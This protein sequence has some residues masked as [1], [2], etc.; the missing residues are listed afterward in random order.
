MPKALIS[1]LLFAAIVPN[2]L[3]QAAPKQ[4]AKPAP[5]TASSLST[6]AGRVAHDNQLPV[7][8]VVLYKNGV[9]YFEHA[10]RVRGSQE[11]NIDFTT[12]QLNDVL[13]SLTVVDMG[14]GQ[15][16]GVRYNSIA[17]LSERLRTLRVQL[18]EDTTRA[19]FLG[20]LRGARVEVRSGGTSTLGKLLSVEQV[21][22][23][24]GREQ[25]EEITQFA[26]VTDTGEM[27][28]FD[29][30]PAVSVRIAEPELNQEIGQYMTAI[31]SSRARDV[32]RMS[33]GTA[34]TGERDLF[35]S[36]ISEVPVWKSTY[37][38]LLPS[39]SGEKALLQGWAI[40][41][42]TV[43]E[44]WK[45][46]QLSLVAGSP[47]SFIQQISQPYYVRR[48]SI[49]LPKS[50]MLTPQTHEGTMEAENAPPPPQVAGGQMGGVIGGILGSPPVASGS[51]G[52]G[53][54]VRVATP[55]RSIKPNAD[56]AAARVMNW[57]APQID[58][59]EGSSVGDLF[60]YAIKQ[61]I[62]VSKNQSALVPIVNA[63]VEAEK[64]T[65]W[66]EQQKQPLRALWIKNSSGLTLDG[67]TFNIVD[68]DAFAGEGILTQLHPDERRLVSYAADT[69]LRVHVE[70]RS[71]NRPVTHVRIA[72][73]I[74][75]MT[76]EQRETRKYTVRNS[77][78]DARSLV[79]EHPAR[80]GW[81]FADGV[82]PE[83]SSENLHRFRVALEPNTTATLNVE[84]FRPE[85]VTYYV[86]NIDDNLV[87]MFVRDRTINPQVEQALRRVLAKKNEI[88]AVDAQ[89]AS[90]RREIGQIGNEQVRLRENM[91]ALKGSAEEKALLQRYVQTLNQ[92]EDRLIALN[93]EIGDLDAKR[94]KLGADLDQMAQEIVLDEK[95]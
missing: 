93:R 70:T 63:R 32:R 13:K 12:S 74:M 41:D 81:K 60:Q 30:T 15:I 55:S 36:Y 19:S 45:D 76:R 95:M 47:Q 75:R 86:S 14:G 85:D 33:I 29:L 21:Q 1:A 38:I 4:A 23:S 84:E 71:M 83:E 79:V 66:N 48:S 8:R 67:G 17:P 90:R 46:V 68:G 49:E 27:R 40:V 89:L 3:A 58:A 82:K 50:A 54:R 92:H 88:G 43:G 18:G 25:Q 51:G 28:T 53:Y 20:A 22:R 65:L 26:V 72:K 16:T 7:R 24:T 42:N 52:A 80:N 56:E 34:G 39:K 37:R 59:A 78:K 31:S 94:V 2:A 57:L 73:G 10:G 35:V 9:G 61:K 91:K 6:S 5:E 64:V 62:T 69:A 87:A 44:D 11:V 77:D